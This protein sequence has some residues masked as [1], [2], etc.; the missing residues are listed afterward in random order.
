MKKV[1]FHAAL[2]LL[3]SGCTINQYGPSVVV[4]ERQ[5]DVSQYVEVESSVPIASAMPHE[6]HKPKPHVPQ[7]I[8]KTAPKPRHR[9]CVPMPKVSQPPKLDVDLLAHFRNDPA[10][11]EQLFRKNHADLYN[12]WLKIKKDMDDWEKNPNRC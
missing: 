12:G 10:K 11:L 4:G 1:I 5:V 9:D 6:T 8:Y 7:V 2:G 3:L